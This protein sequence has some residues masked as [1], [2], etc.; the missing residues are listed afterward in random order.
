MIIARIHIP[1]KDSVTVFPKDLEHAFKM[2]GQWEGNINKRF[3]A[4]DREFITFKRTR[5]FI[6]IKD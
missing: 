1:N 4:A 6:T 3:K 5:D 2:L